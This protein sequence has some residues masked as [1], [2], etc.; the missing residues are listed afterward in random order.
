MKIPTHRR[1]VDYLSE[2]EG[3]NPGPWIDHS[4]H[5]AHAAANIAEDHP[6]LVPEHAYVLGLLHDIGRR[7]GV[8][9]MRHVVD[10]YCFMMREGYPDVT[11]SVDTTVRS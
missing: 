11:Q 1:A 2:A 3:L 7:E 5:V 9:G 6:E 8:F 4:R 10:G